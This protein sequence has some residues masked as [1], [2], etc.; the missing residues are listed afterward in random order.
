MIENVLIY[1]FFCILNFLSYYMFD[2]IVILIKIESCFYVA[3]K[4]HFFV[5]FFI[6]EKYRVLRF[7]CY[8][9]S[10]CKRIYV[11]IIYN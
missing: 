11:N 3:I 5:S 6:N 7:S 9:I 10:L 4:Y 2:N 1:N 8:C